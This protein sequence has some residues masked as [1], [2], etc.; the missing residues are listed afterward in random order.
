MAG[1]VRQ[2]GE[3]VVR[4][5]AAGLQATARG[6]VDRAA[7]RAE[8]SRVEGRLLRR[9][10]QV[11][12]GTLALAGH[13]EHV[14]ASDIRLVAVELAT[15]VDQHHVAFLQYLGMLH[16][17]GE[18]A[19]LAEQHDAEGR[20]RRPHL[21]VR[22]VDELGDLKG[23][24]AFAQDAGGSLV[25]FQGHVLGPL[26]QRQLGGGLA[27]TARVDH[28]GGI[29]EIEVRTEAAD[30]VEHEER[31]GWAQAHH[32]ARRDAHALEHV[33][34]QAIGALVLL[35][36]VDNSFNLAE[37]ADGAFL[38]G[39]CDI[40]QRAIGGQ[41]G[42]DHA[43]ARAPLHAAEVAQVAAGV[44][45]DGRDA[46]LTHQA[47]GPGDARLVF[48]QADRFHP[49]RHVRQA[50]QRLFRVLATHAHC[51]LVLRVMLQCAEFKFHLKC[52]QRHFSVPL[53]FQ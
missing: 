8:A 41:H 14:A 13:A 12:E 24:D 2:T 38:E 23:A 9:L 53:N 33:Q 10:L 30:A 42:A 36:G 4:P 49:R 6:G 52:R 50:C 39:G 20:S 29:D 22:L 44:Q 11:P 25:H 26:H 40:G 35:P 46:L 16:A 3:L 21:A 27:E 34:Q 47:L 32:R 48:G 37:V 45:V 1:T 17:M 31:E 28:A 5:Q 7:R 51:H 15:G 19:G 43:F 18:G